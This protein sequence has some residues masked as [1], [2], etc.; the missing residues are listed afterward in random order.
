MEKQDQNYTSNAVS[1]GKEKCITHMHTLLIGKKVKIGTVVI[2]DFYFK[3]A[4]I[5]QT[6]KNMHVEIFI[7]RILQYH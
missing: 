7:I 6:F 2:S 4:R 3:V 5:F 1:I